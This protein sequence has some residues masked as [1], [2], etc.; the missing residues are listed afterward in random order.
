LQKQDIGSPVRLP[1][2]RVV[3]LLG[4]IT[5][6]AMLVTFA[7]RSERPPDLARHDPRLHVSAAIPKGWPTQSFDNEVGNA[8]HTGFVVSN[9]AHTFGYPGLGGGGATSAWD[10]TKL[11][12]HAVVVEIGRVVR[13]AVKCNSEDGNMPVTDFPLSLDDA[14]IINTGP[15]FGSPPRL[16]IPVCLNNGSHFTVHAWF[17]PE[18]TARDRGLAEELVS[19]IYPAW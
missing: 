3:L 14:E 17:F 13:F 18:A 6:T 10:M 9:V 2:F 16:Y 19:S 7:A 11:P 5:V 1:R 8:T 12:P 15:R 4:A